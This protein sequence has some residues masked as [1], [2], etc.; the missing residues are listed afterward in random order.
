MER[1]VPENLVQ[2]SIS[3]TKY[4]STGGSTEH[5][6]IQ[7]QTTTKAKGS[8]RLKV[9]CVD[10]AGDVDKILTIGSSKG[11]FNVAVSHLL[12]FAPGCVWLFHWNNCASK[13]FAPRDTCLPKF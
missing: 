8:S 9:A 6:K 12:P 11:G 4:N 3:D 5:R 1:L 13:Y 10:L 7:E 2:F